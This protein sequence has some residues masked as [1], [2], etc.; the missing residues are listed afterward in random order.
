[1]T[2]QRAAATDMYLSEVLDF[3][4]KVRTVVKLIKPPYVKHL[5]ENLHPIF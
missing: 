1:M 4:G 2:V 3:W 5:K